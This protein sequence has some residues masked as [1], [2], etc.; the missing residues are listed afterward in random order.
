M[1]KTTIFILVLLINISLSLKSQTRIK[2]DKEGAIYTAPCEV[3]GLKL[4]FSMEPELNDLK[5]SQ[6]EAVFMLNNGYLEDK[7]IL[8]PFYPSADNNR[9]SDILDNVW[10]NLREIK[11]GN[12]R[13]LNIKAY[14]SSALST[15]VVFGKSVLQQLGTIRTEGNELVIFDYDYN[16]SS[17]NGVFTDPTGRKVSAQNINSPYRGNAIKSFVKEPH[18][19]KIITDRNDINN[20]QTSA[21]RSITNGTKNPNRKN[22]DDMGQNPYVSRDM[23]G[24]VPEYSSSRNNSMYI[25]AELPPYTSIVEQRE[26]SLRIGADESVGRI[27][28]VESN[29]AN[30]SE[31]DIYNI[32][33]RGYEL[34][35]SGRYSE[36]VQYFNRAAGQTGGIKSD[37]IRNRGAEDWGRLIKMI[38]TGRAVSNQMNGNFDGAISDYG[39]ILEVYD[40]FKLIKEKEDIF[41]NMGEIYADIK[42]NSQAVSA[43]KNAI[44][45]R[46]QNNFSDAES[47]TKLRNGTL[48]DTFLADVTYSMAKCYETM[49]DYDG[50]EAALKD[51][52]ALGNEDAK[53]I[54]GEALPRNEFVAVK[55]VKTESI[56]FNKIS[57]NIVSDDRNWEIETKKEKNNY[58]IFARN[59]ASYCALKIFAYK[60]KKTLNEYA[61]DYRS[62]IEKESGQTVINRKQMKSRFDSPGSIDFSYDLNRSAEYGGRLIAFEKDKTSYIIHMQINKNASDDVEELNRMF[63]TIRID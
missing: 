25:A 38:Y 1:N 18:E 28:R 47:S 36:A 31:S 54:I 29:T 12:W 9:T 3:N 24:A 41:K 15:P 57:L 27:N 17:V 30:V 7:D 58:H 53:N 60:T 20:I 6:S 51:A 19:S 10:V 34:T 46:I 52:A 16:S 14:V 8:G 56:V 39:K 62:S 33:D 26:G 63:E 11:I 21:Y 48:K 2:M 44:Y 35:A 32:V 45:F 23:G 43:F 40:E 4:R 59:K 22:Y 13:L 42:S 61:L 5:I 37:F 55:Q 49:G 50:F